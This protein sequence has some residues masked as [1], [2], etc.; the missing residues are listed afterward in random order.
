MYACTPYLFCV[1]LEALA[2]QPIGASNQKSIKE[3]LE[4]MNGM[5]MEEVEELI[6]TCHLEP[7]YDRSFTKV[8]V[9]LRAVGQRLAVV[10]SLQQLDYK[11][12]AS[13]A[14]AGYMEEQLS[15]MIKAMS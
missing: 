13:R 9:A 15:S 4:S 7:C 8:V 3:L 5:E 11:F 1:L 12:H 6:P 14:P 2:D 10:R